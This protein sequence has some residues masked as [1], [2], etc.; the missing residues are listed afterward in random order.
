MDDADDARQWQLMRAPGLQVAFLGSGAITPAQQ[1]LCECLGGHL[2]PKLHVA[3]ATSGYAGQIARG[4]RSFTMTV[5][6]SFA[7]RLPASDVDRRVTSFLVRK[8]DGSLPGSLL[9][10][11]R[12]VVVRGRSLMN[13]QAQIIAKSDVLCVG[14]GG[15]GTTDFARLA[16]QIDKPMLPLPFM[17]GASQH[18]WTEFGDDIRDEFFI[19][20]AQWQRWSD[21]DLDLLT[22]EQ[23]DSLAAEV[24]ATLL[25]SA[26][27][28]C[29][30]CMPFADRHLPLYASIIEPAIAGAHLLAVRM[31][32]TPSVG[33]IVDTLRA[34]IEAARCVV[35]V[36][37]EQNPNV[38]YEVGFAHALRKPVVLMRAAGAADGP[39]VDLPFDV[40]THRV[41]T[42]PAGLPADG[43]AAARAELHALLRA[44]S[45]GL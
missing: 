12:R 37:D 11:G 41:V 16:L 40:R 44:I 4:R 42:Y 8:R 15:Q 6:Q 21:I 30:V 5:A 36:V 31:D 24:A 27:G 28:T 33:D 1:T 39:A 35:A 2:A 29:L 45:H 43:T 22:T 34:E 26:R 13:R 7:D 14:G 25:R 19:D 10:L 38:L 20:A 23:I 3:V 17:G 9:G 32:H 18:L